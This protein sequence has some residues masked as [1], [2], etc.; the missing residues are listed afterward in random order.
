[1]PLFPWL[2]LASS[3]FQ[4]STRKSPMKVIVLPS[5][6]RMADNCT[7]LFHRLDRSWGQPPSRDVSDVLVQVVHREVHQARA[8]AIGVASDLDPSTVGHP[9]FDEQTLHRQVVGGTAEETL[10]P[11]VRSFEVGH[12]DDGEDMINRHP[13]FLRY[14]ANG[15]QGDPRAAPT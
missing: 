15:R 10:V 3:R 1:M 5:G 9:P 8:G 12:R 13:L 2:V 6:S 7:P 14:R 11:S 4:Y